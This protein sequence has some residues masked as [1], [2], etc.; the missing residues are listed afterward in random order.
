MTLEYLTE[1]VFHTLKNESGSVH[2]ARDGLQLEQI[3]SSTIDAYMNRPHSAHGIYTPLEVLEGRDNWL[4]VKKVIADAKKE[5]VEA[6]KVAR[7]E[8]CSCSVEEGCS[9]GVGENGNGQK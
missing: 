5:R 3:L 1:R 7:C 9:E 2:V 4:D 8:N 6:N